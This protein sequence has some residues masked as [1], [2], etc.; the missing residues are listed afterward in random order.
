[1]NF[2][3]KPMALRLH[4]FFTA[5]VDGKRAAPAAPHP[6]PLAGNV[7]AND[8][9]DKAFPRSAKTFW[10]DTCDELQTSLG[11]VTNDNIYG[12]NYG[13]F[14]GH[15]QPRLDGLVRPPICVQCA[16]ETE[17]EAVGRRL[18]LAQLAGWRGKPAGIELE[19][20]L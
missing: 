18:N 19:N 14:L 13:L 6:R 12:T 9:C 11:F 1:M 4:W 2:A 7:T 17:I 16:P 15:V 8:T 20:Q 3:L 5:Q 10:D